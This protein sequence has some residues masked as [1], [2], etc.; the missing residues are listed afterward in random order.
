MK[1]FLLVVLAI[2]LFVGCAQNS[3]EVNSR[4][5]KIDNIKVN[6]N[7]SSDTKISDIEFELNDLGVYDKISKQHIL[8]GMSKEE[9]EDIIGKPDNDAK[10]IYNYDG[11]G[12]RYRNDIVVALFL[13]YH[14]KD[15]P[16]ER[17]E[18]HRKTTIGSTKREVLTQYGTKWQ[19]S[20]SGYYLLQKNGNKVRCLAD[21]SFEDLK[22]IKLNNIY[23]YIINFF[24]N[25]NMEVQTIL[26]GDKD[27]F[28]NC[29]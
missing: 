16:W 23:I 11:L 1:R 5:S 26:I 27:Y 25:E 18:T 9:V 17:Y 10:E 6:G 2:I 22:D 19:S 4:V 13:D 8:L 24:L 28:I 12:I 29:Q 20:R 7:E 3:A 14:N 21:K 15:K